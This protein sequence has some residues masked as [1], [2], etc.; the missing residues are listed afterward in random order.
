MR[1][2]PK[3]IG[4]ELEK[5]RAYAELVYG[6]RSRIACEKLR[7]IEK[8]LAFDVVE[9]YEDGR[10]GDFKRAQSTQ[11]PSRISR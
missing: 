3:N 5:Q 11:G 10:T 2:L 9:A 6:R 4:F 1:L 7:K 8:E